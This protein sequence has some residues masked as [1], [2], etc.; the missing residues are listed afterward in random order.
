MN[1][2]KVRQNKYKKLSDRKLCQKRDVM[3]REKH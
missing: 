2:V 3:N 1:I